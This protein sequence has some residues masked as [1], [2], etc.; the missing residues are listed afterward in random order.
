MRYAPV[1]IKKNWLVLNA[2]VGATLHLQ[3]F[4]RRHLAI[5]AS[6]MLL[7]HGAWMPVAEDFPLSSNREI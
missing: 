5:G 7:L 4:M 2:A 1:E 3:K 6:K